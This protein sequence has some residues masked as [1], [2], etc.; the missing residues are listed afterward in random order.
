M[1]YERNWKQDL[2]FCVF[3][4]VFVI[5]VGWLILIPAFEIRNRGIRFIAV[6]LTA[7]IVATN[8]V[9]WSW[10]IAWNLRRRKSF[11][12]VV[13]S[14]YVEC[15]SP[16]PIRGTSFKVPINRIES[17]HRESV[18]DGEK[19]FLTMIGG[20]EIEITYWYKNPVQKIISAILTENPSIAYWHFGKLTR[21]E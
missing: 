7:L 11:R 16:I 19:C 10:G 21:P 17:I 14:E 5:I 20:E 13:N 8:L 15:R 2:V 4:L 18:G 1:V 9:I 12:F 3:A 6:G